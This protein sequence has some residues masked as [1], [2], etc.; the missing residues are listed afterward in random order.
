VSEYRFLSTWCIDAPIDA[1]FSAIDDCGDWPK[2]W[3]GMRRAELLEDAGQ[4]GQG[5]LW[6]YSWR[7][8][9]PYDLTFDARVTRVERPFLLEAQ[10]E[11]ELTGVGRW[12]FYEGQGTAVVYEWNVRTTK[13]WMNS[14]APVARPLFAWNHD[15]VMRRGAKGLSRLLQAPLLVSG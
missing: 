4:G 14:L 5:N 7:S 9:L 15:V 3:R 1:V 2:W 11:G 13:A 6:R 12:R 8:R 10:A